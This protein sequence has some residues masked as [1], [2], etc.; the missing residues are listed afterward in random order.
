[1]QKIKD[2][3]L[4][5][6]ASVGGVLV[7]V[8]YILFSLTVT[9]FV[10]KGIILVGDNIFGQ[11]EQSGGQHVKSQYV[12]TCTEELLRRT[13]SKQ[14]A[15]REYCVCLYDAIEDEAGSASKVL[16]YQNSVPEERIVEISGHCRQEYNG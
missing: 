12:G 16:D 5:I 13:D 10:I 8:L 3:L 15:A 4:G 9:Y 6:G 2:I 11:Q 14:K 7:F 1:M